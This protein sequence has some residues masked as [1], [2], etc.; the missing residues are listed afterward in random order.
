MARQLRRDARPDLS[1]AREAAWYLTANDDAGGGTYQVIEALR[2]R[3]DDRGQGA[4]LQHALPR[5]PARAH[6]RGH[7]SPERSCRAQIIF[8]EAEIDRMNKRDPA[9]C[10]CP[11]DAAPPARVLRQ[12]VRVLRARRRAVRVQDQGHGASCPASTGTCWRAADTGTDRLKDLGCQTRNGLSVRALMTVLIV[13]QGA[14]PTS[15]ATARWRSRTCAR[16]CRSCCTTS[17][18]PDP[19]RAVLRGRRE[20]VLRIDRVAGSAA[21]RPVV[22]G[23]RP[24]RPRPRRSGGACSTEVQPGP[25]GLDGSRG[26]RDGW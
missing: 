26:A 6:R 5:R 7:R 16:S 4:A 22:R 1:S 17:C 8:T 23:V 14:W 2:D 24:A 21:V 10:A 15:A 25:G 20:R 11:P 18:S 3:I 9:R 12:P 19:G 13:R